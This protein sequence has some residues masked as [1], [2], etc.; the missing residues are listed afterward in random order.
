[1]IINSTRETTAGE[2]TNPEKFFRPGA[3]KII[4]VIAPKEG[5]MGGPPSHRSMLE[6]F[7]QPPTKDDHFRKLLIAVRILSVKK[8]KS[9]YVVKLRLDEVDSHDKTKQ[10]GLFFTYLE[11]GEHDAKVFSRFK[12][13]GSRMSS[14]LGAQGGVSSPLLATV[15]PM[16]LFS[17]TKRRV[18]FMIAG[19]T[20]VCSIR[21]E[22]KPGIAVINVSASVF[23][24][25]SRGRAEESWAKYFDLESN[26]MLNKEA[27]GS[28][29]VFIHFQETQKWKSEND[30]LWETMERTDRDG[31]MMMRCRVIKDGVKNDRQ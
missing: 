30:W 13:D 11:I 23:E 29:K 5:F 26:Q 14:E 17:T 4:E 7:R 15:P 25:F 22:A 21:E 12:D 20:G 31:N 2:V 24:H 16:F 18:S 8:E 6:T 9:R 3:F 28:T 27:A 1:M 19:D 10:E